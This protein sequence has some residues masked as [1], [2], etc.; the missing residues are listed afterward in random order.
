MPDHSPQLSD[1]D[2]GIDRQSPLHGYR[3]DRDRANQP[4]APTGLTVALSREAGSRGTSIATRAAE[5]LGWQIY[6]QE[7]LEYIAQEA[8]VQEEITAALSP[9]ALEWVEQQLTRL[10]NSPRNGVHPSVLDMARVVLS[11]GATGDMFLIGRGAGYI[12]PRPS[13]LHVRVVAPLDDRIAYM[14]QWLR[15][16]REEAAEQVK[17]RD[18]RRIDYLRSHYHRDATDIYLYDLL[19][20]ST[21]LGEEL[22]ADLLVQA[23]KTKAATLRA[24]VS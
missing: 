19:L 7:M 22:S 21:L 20:N 1:P 18:R 9:P 3:G 13:T 12:L 5:K 11:L 24:E 4:F 2:L 6:T 17:L 8:T 23:A 14:S 10:Q 16:T 15:L